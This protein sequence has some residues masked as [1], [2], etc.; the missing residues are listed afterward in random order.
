MYLMHQF[1]RS[2]IPILFGGL[3]VDNIG[4]LLSES[5]IVQ[6]HKNNFYRCC[7]LIYCVVPTMKRT[8]A[9]LEVSYTSIV[10]FVTG[11]VYKINY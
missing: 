6:K 1:F 8:K 4:H 10:T 2:H 7:K 11:H 5:L 3:I 9:I